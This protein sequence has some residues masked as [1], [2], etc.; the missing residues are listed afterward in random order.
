MKSIKENKKAYF[1]YEILDELITGIVLVG[2]EVKSIK[3]G[4]VNL[5]GTYLKFI[6]GE[7]Y[8]TNMHVGS[9]KPAGKNGHENERERKLLI[10]KTELLK[11][12]TKTDIKGN[13]LVPLEL[14]LKD[15][16]IKV[17]IALVRGK[18]QYEK[19]QVIKE[20]EQNREIRR[21]LKNF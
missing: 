20:R 3:L 18:K 21:K 19:K 12:A 5:R 17:K 9:Y 15:N 13:S 2:S 1:D 4:N 14:L 6:N 16:L 10:K 11:L 7:L 8:L